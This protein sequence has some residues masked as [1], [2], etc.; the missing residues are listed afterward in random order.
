M[1]KLKIATITAV[2]SILLF[3]AMAFAEEPV[4]VWETD[5][6][7]AKAKADK[8]GKDL[9]VFFLAKNEFES[10][11]L[12]KALLSKPNLQT[13]LS[14]KYILFRF[15][16]AKD[17]KDIPEAM[18]K[19]IIEEAFKIGLYGF[20][21]MTIMDSKGRVYFICR[22]L[23]F[24]T[25][26]Q[27]AEFL[28][29]V[30]RSEISKLKRDEQFAKADT[31][32]GKDRV[33]ELNNAFFFL[34]KFGNI[35]DG[36][37]LFGYDNEIQEII[38]ADPDNITGLKDDWEYRIAIV[39]GR[40]LMLNNDTAGAIAV[41]DEFLKTHPENKKHRQGIIYNKA[42]LYSLAGEDEACMKAI[43]ETIEIDPESDI[44]K[45][46]KQ[47]FEEVTTTPRAAQ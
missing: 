22:K 10:D 36:Y 3:S 4:Q 25:Q 32:K 16:I 33:M 39:K 26:D 34:Q 9:L 45:E 7:A 14:K 41:M 47:I 30:K 6:V 38:K 37:G 40:R 2:A 17:K 23:E 18:Q 21:T 20:P 43:V 24:V 19:I 46:A 31:V 35:F 44:G 8:D 13:E 27:V 12:E 29:I 42:Q 28:E 5:L 15:D 11:V 1:R